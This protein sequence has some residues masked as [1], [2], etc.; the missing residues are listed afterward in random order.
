M[1]RPKHAATR[2]PKRPVPVGAPIAVDSDDA[3]ADASAIRIRIGRFV[4]VDAAP[5]NPIA[6][7]SRLPGDEYAA[8]SAYLGE[9]KAA[10]YDALARGA[11]RVSNT[12]RMW[13]SFSEIANSC[14]RIRGEV[15][16]DQTKRNLA[17]EWLWESV[18][19]GD[20][21]DGFDDG[22]DE[23]RET[24]TRLAFLHPSPLTGIR[25]KR[26]P[27]TGA[28]DH[29]APRV[30]LRFRTKWASDREN[31][32]GWIDKLWMRR[33]DCGMWFAKVGV[34]PPA[35]W[36]LGLP[37]IFSIGPVDKPSDDGT[38]ESLFL[39][40]L[41]KKNDRPGKNEICGEVAREAK[42]KGNPRVSTRKVLAYADRVGYKPARP[43]G[44]RKGFSTKK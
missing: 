35:D 27:V 41:A 10:F 7:V 26:S 23:I 4:T 18:L 20:F 13:F 33:A 31:F 30:G 24:R 9:R 39:S 2:D 43:R 16:F 28:I 32:K 29:C 37:A 3:L 34:A 25:F 6:D 14:A 44:H 11:K 8:W 17:I 42:A 19:A 21:D 1:A 40:V 38:I 5:Q 22:D 15:A 12:N 36:G